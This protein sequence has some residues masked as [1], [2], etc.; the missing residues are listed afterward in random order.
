MEQNIQFKIYRDN[1]LSLIETYKPILFAKML[2]WFDNFDAWVASSGRPIA[3]VAA[4]T[5]DCEQR[6]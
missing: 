3:V 2:T 4:P 1:K 6:Q 5:G